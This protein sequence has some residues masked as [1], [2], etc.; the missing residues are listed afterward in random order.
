MEKTVDITRDLGDVPGFVRQALIRWIE[1][2][3]SLCRTPGT[4]VLDKIKLTF[5]FHPLK[6]GAPR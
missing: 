5:Q 6:S 2:E 4:V 3:Y 1:G